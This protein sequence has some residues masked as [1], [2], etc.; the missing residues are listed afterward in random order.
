MTKDRMTYERMT[1]DLGALTKIEA[2][3]QYGL[4]GCF[5]GDEAHAAVEAH[6]RFVAVPYVEGKI[7]AA[8]PSGVFLC[9]FIQPTA[10]AF[11]TGSL[12][13]AQV[14]DI[15]CFD[16]LQMTARGIVL[17]HA[18]TV[19]KHTTLLIDI[20]KDGS[21]RICKNP[22]KFRSR[23]FGMSF[24]KQIGTHFGMHV[25]HL[26]QQF[27]N[28]INILVF[29]F[30]NHCIMN[31]R[32][33]GFSTS[34]SRNKLRSG[35]DVHPGEGEQLHAEVFQRGSDVIRIFIDYQETVVGFGVFV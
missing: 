31:L 27:K 26:H 16:L 6:G 28:I 2:D 23:V 9:M 8:L 1:N 15:K 18:E 12:I 33:L 32:R 19:A 21:R 14:V 20:H 10:H 22:F 5:L 30:T 4:K 35:H 29:S 3:S 11:A 7:M 13:Y 34:E 24:D 25:I 17:K